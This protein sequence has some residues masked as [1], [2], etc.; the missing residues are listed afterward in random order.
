MKTGCFSTYKGDEGIA[1]CIVPPVSWKGPMYRQ[2]NPPMDTFTSIKRG[3]INQQ[4]YERQYV[5]KVLDRLDPE[6]VLEE[7]MGKVLL[8]WE[9]PWFD[10]RGNVI[11]ERKG[12]CHRHIAAHWI[13]QRTGYPVM[14]WRPEKITEKSLKL[15]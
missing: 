1:I 5:E 12:F 7:L 11:N 13:S 15:F 4:E 3:L 10:E 2:L 14:E 6:R 9:R 8:C